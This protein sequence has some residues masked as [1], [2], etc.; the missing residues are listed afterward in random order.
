MTPTQS[1]LTLP[2]LSGSWVRGGV[3]DHAPLVLA[4][5]AAVSI[6]SLVVAVAT[7]APVANRVEVAQHLASET[8]IS[9]SANIG[10]RLDEIAV[11]GRDF[12]RPR[13]ILNA[14]DVPQGGPLLALD[15]EQARKNL[16][17]LPW[18]KHAMVERRLPN[19]VR[20]DLV[21]RTPIALWQTRDGLY[22]LVDADGVVIDDRVGA[23]QNLPVVVGA[24]AP[25]AASDLLAMLNGLPELAPR[26]TAAV[27][28]GQRR[29]DLWLDG[30]GAQSESDGDPSSPD[31]A[32]TGIQV[33]LPEQGAELA[34]ARLAQLDREQGLLQRDIAVIDLRQQDRLIIRRTLAPRAPTDPAAPQSKPWQGLPL[35]GPAQDA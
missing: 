15:P 19:G 35:G 26:I 14:L 16:E 5:L 18:V 28:F 10:L 34:L 21:E 13:D 3:R 7:S 30:Y 12:T 23:Y 27:R 24:G 6:G 1:S 17:A 8:F 31:Q 33:R 25:E 20:I 29:W 2:S 32:S 9:T 11:S 22:H 4:I